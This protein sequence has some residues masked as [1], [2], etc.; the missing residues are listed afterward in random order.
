MLDG[1][2]NGF[3][4]QHLDAACIEEA[5][6]HC[7]EIIDSQE[8]RLLFLRAEY[9]NAKHAAVV[10]IRYWN[11]RIALFGKDK[12]FLPLT[13]SGALRDDEVGLGMGFI[14]LSPERDSSG[15]AIIIVDQSK[16]E[17]KNYTRNMMLRVVWYIIHAALEDETIQC[18]G[19]V[20]LC[21][22]RNAEFDQFDRKLESKIT[23][24]LRETLPVI[25]KGLH[26]CHA[27]GFYELVAPN[28]KYLL[29]RRMRARTRWHRGSFRSVLGTLAEY[30]INSTAIPTDIGGDW[31]VDGSKWLEERQEKNL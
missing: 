22:P 9:F 2:S 30:G 18:K 29:G 23:H 1:S 6:R 3:G 12:A 25:W 31:D 7:P 5:K 27:P 16:L 4:L 28:A 14:L 15:R 20:M 24:S 19:I 8:H 13:I 26:I 17:R 10:L 11:E 21:T